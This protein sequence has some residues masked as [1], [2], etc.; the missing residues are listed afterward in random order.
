MEKTSDGWVEARIP[1]GEME[2]AISYAVLAV[3]DDMTAA[4]IRAVS[5][6]AVEELKARG[7]L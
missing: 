5:R 2:Q 3:A 4:E 1:D 7:V 6:R